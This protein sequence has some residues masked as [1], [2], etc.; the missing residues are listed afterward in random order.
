MP[1][2]AT[3]KQV[4]FNRATHGLRGI[5]SVMVFLAHLIG[6]TAEHI[7]A[8]RAD[9]V[10]GVAPFWNFGT[11]GVFLF[12]VI[13]GFVILPSALRYSASEF[14]ARRF[15]RIYPLFFV[16]SL[17][18][19]A[20]NA[21]THVEPKTNDPGAILAALTFVNIFTRT[22]QLTPN[23][24]S[25]TFEVWFYVMTVI[26]VIVFV[27]TPSRTAQILL[28][29]FVGYFLSRFPSAFYFIGGLLVRVIADGTKLL[30]RPR[31]VLEAIAFA[32]LVALA[33]R[34]HWGYRWSDMHNPVL[35]ALIVVTTAYFA[36]AIAPG[37][38]TARLLDNRAAAWLGTISYSLYLVHPYTYL[39]TRMSFAHLGW[40]GDT[41]T[42][43]MTAFIAVT[44]LVTLP[45]TILA[46]RLLERAPY[47]WV[48]KQRVFA[49]GSAR[50]LRL[51]PRPRAARAARAES[52][53]S[54]ESV[55]RG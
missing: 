29:V 14:A 6:G 3:D 7:Y 16:L 34:G 44:T 21:L 13:S 20:L 46:H 47:E 55:G 32:A 40:F 54:A 11:Y 39:A 27:K 28:L 33:S 50:P 8:G 19:V 36:L 24:W 49:T 35:P 52:A 12:F 4:S 41:I 38:L 10:D 22:L 18:Y 1:R 2:S 9:Y 26:G 23:A 31:P 51:W 42:L 25:L 15:M 17:V 5:A 37:S 48:F 53:E 30:Q 45:A 43:S